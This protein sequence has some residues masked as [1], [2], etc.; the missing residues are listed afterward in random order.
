MWDSEYAQKYLKARDYPQAAADAL[1]EMHRQVGPLKV[2]EEGVALRGVLVR[3]LVM[4][5]DL[6]GTANVM[7]FL[8]EEL[9]PDTFVNLMDQYYP[10]GKVTPD[11][12]GEINRRLYTS[13]MRAAQEAALDAGIWRFDQRRPRFLF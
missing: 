5:G 6:A 7:A 4:P 9:S 12:Y 8:A 2:D 1:K 10:A 3:H 11:K 13:E